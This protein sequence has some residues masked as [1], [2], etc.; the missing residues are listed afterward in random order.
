MCVD[1]GLPFL[2]TPPSAGAVLHWKR[3]EAR[4]KRE[5]QKLDEY[6]Q[7]YDR[8]TEEASRIRRMKMPESGQESSEWGAYA[9]AL[10]RLEYLDEWFAVHE[11]R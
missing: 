6:R 7:E 9:A 8:L 3:E 4:R 1:F 10:A 5:E 2:R 11:W